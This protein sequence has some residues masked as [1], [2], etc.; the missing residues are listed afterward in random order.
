MTP[1]EVLRPFIKRYDLPPK[2]VRLIYLLLLAESEHNFPALGTPENAEIRF[3]K[4][5]KHI[6]D[7]LPKMYDLDDSKFS[8]QIYTL[9]GFEDYDTTVLY[10][11][12]TPVELHN[13]HRWQSDLKSEIRRYQE[14]I[15]SKS[16]GED[17]SWQKIQLRQCKEELKDL[18]PPNTT[19][20]LTK[21]WTDILF[22]NVSFEI[23]AKLRLQHTLIC[24]ATGS[25]KTSLLEK[26]I[27]ADIQTDAAVIVMT[28]KGSLL[29]N[30]ARLKC[31]DPD[32]LIFLGPHNLIP[33]NIFDLGT[34]SD[35]AVDLIN[36]VFSGILEAETTSKQRPLLN[37]CIRLL[38]KAKGNLNDLRSL[39]KERTLPEEYEQYL[40]L[41]SISGQEFF[42]ERFGDKNYAETKEQLMWRLDLLLENTFIQEIFCQSRTELNIHEVMAQGKILLIDTSVKELGEYGSKFLGRFFLALITIAA[43][44]RNN[45]D[46]AVHVYVDEAASYL[47]QN[48]ETILER[49]RE[50]RVGLTIAIQGLDQLKTL[51]AS[52]MTNTS[53]KYIGRC[54]E[55]DAKKLANTMRVEADAL[56]HQADLH[57]FVKAQ[58]FL[59]KSVQIRVKPGYLATKEQRPY[60]TRAPHTASPPK[61]IPPKSPDLGTEAAKEW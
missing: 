56:H 50:A 40:P 6:F 10:N 43:Q 51:E 24:G 32:R 27:Y 60:Q 16:P 35:S 26:L 7:K 46:R 4:G 36:Q 11:L 41:L 22:F 48:V 28:L 15:D 33:L 9:G 61:D 3:A 55:T 23:P 5:L 57:A 49:T 8:T 53:V 17:V 21:F 19:P 2:L 39:L 59:K 14:A 34:E 44:Q 45:T 38:M 20:Y 54:N 30:L 42:K 12:R 37:H 18:E 29:P 1:E 13:F 47:T 31:I 52:V 58:G 25:G